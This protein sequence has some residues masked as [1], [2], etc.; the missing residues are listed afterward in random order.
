M[1][2]YLSSLE[3]LNERV[4]DNDGIEKE[5]CRGNRC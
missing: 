5:T 3:Q 4:I 2:T 1:R